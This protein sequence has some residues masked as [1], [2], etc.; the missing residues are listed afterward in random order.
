MPKSSSTDTMPGNRVKANPWAIPEEKLQGLV[1]GIPDGHRLVKTIFFNESTIPDS[2]VTDEE[3]IRKSCTTD[4]ITED[5]TLVEQDKDDVL[6][7]G[8]SAGF[9]LLNQLAELNRKVDIHE[10]RIEFLENASVVAL[11]SRARETSRYIMQKRKDIFNKNRFKE[12]SI[13]A[14]GDRAVHEGDPVLDAH[15]LEKKIRKSSYDPEVYKEIYGLEWQQV[16]SIRK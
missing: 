5:E 8:N 2:S 7:V 13:K 15:V 14:A 10:E 6:R 11:K 9:G 12:Y 1:Q 4:L 3:T 16:L